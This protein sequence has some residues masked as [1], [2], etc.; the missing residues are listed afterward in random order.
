M[1]SSTREM[2]PVATSTL[3]SYYAEPWR[4]RGGNLLGYICYGVND[5]YIADPHVTRRNP[6]TSPLV[7]FDLVGAPCLRTNMSYWSPM[8]ISDEM[9]GSGAEILV[10]NS[11]PGVR[12]AP[13]PKLIA[14]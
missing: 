7:R 5:G 1:Q 4:V 3:R 12:V 8:P 13:P 9:K 11:F 6:T 2:R 10:V 14:Y